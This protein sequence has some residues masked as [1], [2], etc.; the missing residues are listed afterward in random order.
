MMTHCTAQITDDTTVRPASSEQLWAA[1][2]RLNVPEEELR[3]LVSRLRVEHEAF[4]RVASE[5]Y[6]LLGQ[7]WD[8][9]Q[10]VR[11][12][13]AELSES[14]LEAEQSCRPE[15]ATPAG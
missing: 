15:G 13:R 8:A 14:A 4:C 3:Q 12:Q 11:E 6:H 2:E 9:Y 7:A 5:A 1:D 10:S